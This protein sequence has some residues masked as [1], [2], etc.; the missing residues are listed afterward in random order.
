MLEVTTVLAVLYLLGYEVGKGLAIC[1]IITEALM[2]V[3]RIC[4]SIQKKYE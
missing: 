4:K 2:I 1:A 3:L